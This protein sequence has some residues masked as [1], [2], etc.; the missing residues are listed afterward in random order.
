M[1]L[2]RLPKT[3]GLDATDMERHCAHDDDETDRSI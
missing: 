2:S 1:I 3:C